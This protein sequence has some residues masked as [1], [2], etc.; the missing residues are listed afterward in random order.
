M[1]SNLT[2]NLE[3]TSGIDINNHCCPTKIAGDKIVAFSF[4]F[5]DLMRL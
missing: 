3:L 1:N 5:E 2:T 4:K